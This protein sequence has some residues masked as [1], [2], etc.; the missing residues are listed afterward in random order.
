[1]AEGLHRGHRVLEGLEH[2][3]VEFGRGFLGFEGAAGDALEG[4]LDGAAHRRGG[5]SDLVGRLSR[6]RSFPFAATSST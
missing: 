1:L 2:R 6:S 3:A 5:R 4:L